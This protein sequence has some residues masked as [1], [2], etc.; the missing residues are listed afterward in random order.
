M[1]FYFLWFCYT[2][3]YISCRSSIKEDKDLDVNVIMEA[4]LKESRKEEILYKTSSLES[5]GNILS[6]L[7]ID[8]FDE[9]YVIVQDIL[10]KDTG[11][12][13]RDDED[14]TSED[15]SSKREA[16]IKLR[17]TVYEALGK[18]WPSNCKTTQEKYR[19]LFVDHCK[20]CLP[21]T[22]RGIQV[23][24]V[25]ALCS[26]IDKLIILKE[27]DLDEK[28]KDSLTKIVDNLIITLEYSLG[29]YFCTALI[30]YKW[31]I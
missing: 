23:A 1:Y 5:L 12:V 31:Y 18:S 11:H 17:E 2:S 10:S 28:D 21:T 16:N 13:D 6:S 26:F 3:Y 30:M 8:K 14:M 9:I 19:E 4:V 25:T 29:K 22:T 24:I 27:D 15:I 20:I 7:E